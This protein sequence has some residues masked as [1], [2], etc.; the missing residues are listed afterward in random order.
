MLVY[1]VDDADRFLDG[2][3]PRQKEPNLLYSSYGMWL[4]PP[5]KSD[6]DPC[7]E[8][9]DYRLIRLKGMTKKVEYSTFQYKFGRWGSVGIFY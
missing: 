3:K 4:P 7:F 6:V 2:D 1:I 8:S 5:K 9:S